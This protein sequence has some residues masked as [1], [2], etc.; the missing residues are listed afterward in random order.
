MTSPLP[1]TVTTGTAEVDP[2][3]PASGFTV[4][5]VRAADALDDPSTLRAP[6]ASPVKDRVRAARQAEAVE[7]LPE[8]EPVKAPENPPAALTAP[9]KLAAVPLIAPLKAPPARGMAAPATPETA[10][11]TLSMLSKLALSRVPQLSSS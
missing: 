2:N 7:A 4:A 6:E 3:T 9:E 8:S 1:L 10:C 11:T 5:R